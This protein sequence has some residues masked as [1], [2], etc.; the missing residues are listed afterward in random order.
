MLTETR[1]SKM[2]E[3]SDMRLIDITV[4]EFAEFITPIIVSK[5]SEKLSS[6]EGEPDYGYGID[7]IMEMFNC[8]YSKALRIKN[9]PEYSDAFCQDGRKIIVNKT[10]LRDLQV[11]R[12]RQRNRK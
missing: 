12:E 6:K 3:L 10:M 2:K 8:G 9:N 1:F 11:S 7:C 4:G 5:V